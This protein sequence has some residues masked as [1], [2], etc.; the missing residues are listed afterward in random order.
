VL[1]LTGS[2]AAGSDTNEDGLLR[3]A[4]AANAAAE[5]GVGGHREVS[6]EGIYAIDPDAI[7]LAESDPGRASSASL[8]LASPALAGLRA[9]RDDRILRV[10]WSL[11]TTLSQW[12]VVGAEELARAL[13]PNLAAALPPPGASL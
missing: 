12:N 4:G 8:L 1:L 7:V 5:A 10:K 11:V 9:I 13:F 3:L 2:T 6:G